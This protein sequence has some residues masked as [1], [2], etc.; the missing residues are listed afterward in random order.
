M[1]MEAVLVWGTNEQ[2][3]PEPKHKPISPEFKK[4]LQELPLKWTNYFEVNR[5][6]FEAPLSQ[7][8]NV[9]L[10]AKCRLEVR[11]LGQSKVEVSHLGSGK[12]VGTRTQSLPKGETLILGG[13]APGATSWLAV[14]RRLE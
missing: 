7:V 9:A 13:N 1:K 8:T 12:R 4:K 10:S 6:V 11:N 3:S 14:I 2:K 5:V